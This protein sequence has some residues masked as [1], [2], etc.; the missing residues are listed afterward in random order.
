[1]HELLARM[2][3][4]S[5]I[6]CLHNA[7]LLRQPLNLLLHVTH[8]LCA[9]IITPFDLS[10]FKIPISYD[11]K[12]EKHKSFFCKQFH[13][14]LPGIQAVLDGFLTILSPS[15]TIIEYIFISLCAKR[16]SRIFRLCMIHITSN[17]DEA[18][19]LRGD[20]M[21]QRMWFL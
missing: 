12:W 5:F 17:F 16:K 6:S 14:L 9:S 2:V 4:D 18:T 13:E 21:N 19:H 7:C 8:V 1:M 3:M 20:V 15:I 10:R 11:H